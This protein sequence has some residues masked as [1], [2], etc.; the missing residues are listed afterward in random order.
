MKIG[1]LVK[2]YDRL[3]VVVSN[4]KFRPGVSS[5]VE[6]RSMHPHWPGGWI[7]TD[8]PNLELLSKRPNE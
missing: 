7:L 3:Y 5:K 4:T 6:V 1:D 2:Y 8:D